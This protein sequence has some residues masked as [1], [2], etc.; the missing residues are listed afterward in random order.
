MQCGPIK[1]FI[2]YVP[3]V[4]VCIYIYSASWKHTFDFIDTDSFLL[5]PPN[6]GAGGDQFQLN[7]SDLG[8]CCFVRSP[9][10]LLR[11][12]CCAQQHRKTDIQDKQDQK[13]D[14]AERYLH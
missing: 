9:C 11:C 5:S 13:N 2:L 1:S 14:N 12:K 10:N 4:C 8:R 6:S 3:C 7:V